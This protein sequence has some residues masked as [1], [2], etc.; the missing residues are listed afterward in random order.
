VLYIIVRIVS[1]FHLWGGVGLFK[2]DFFN[3]IKGQINYL[4]SNSNQIKGQIK[5]L[6]L[7]LMFYRIKGFVKYLGSDFNQ[8]KV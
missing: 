5:Y 6:G 8:I 3:Q 1:G 4:G 7:S 2:G